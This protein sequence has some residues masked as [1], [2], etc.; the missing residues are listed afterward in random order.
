[1]QSHSKTVMYSLDL[2]H[3][4][5]SILE[6]TTRGVS[7]TWIGIMYKMFNSESGYLHIPCDFRRSQLEFEWLVVIDLNTVNHVMVCYCISS[8]P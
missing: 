7:T 1:M 3:H 8:S 5:Y 2:T 4:G 6:T